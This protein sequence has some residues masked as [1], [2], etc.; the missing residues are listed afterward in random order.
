MRAGRRGVGDRVG[1]LMRLAEQRPLL[2][3]RIDPV[4]GVAESLE[5]VDVLDDA[6]FLVVRLLDQKGVVLDR[7]FGGTSER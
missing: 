7:A 2:R 4:A 5:R 6:L 1:D 3:E